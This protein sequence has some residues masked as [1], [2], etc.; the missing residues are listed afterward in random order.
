M[1]FDLGAALA[2]T[3]GAGAGV[4][5]KVGDGIK[6]KR[7]ETLEE[8]KQLAISR[9]QENL[10]RLQQQFQSQQGDLNRTH[11]SNQTDK[12]IEFNKNEGILNRAAA[13]NL[14]THDQGLADSAPTDLEKK[15]SFL[16][17]ILGEEK[18]NAYIEASVSSKTKTNLDR[19]KFY[20]EIY[21]G[22]IKALS[23]EMG[24]VTDEMKQ[25]ARTLAEQLSGY[26]LPGVSTNSE[27]SSLL[28][29]IK[30]A[31][32]S[33]GKESKTPSQE[34][35]TPTDDEAGILDKVASKITNIP[36]EDSLAGKVERTVK[37]IPQFL[38]DSKAAN[39]QN[40]EAVASKRTDGVSIPGINTFKRETPEA[41]TEVQRIVQITKGIL[42]SDGKSVTFQPED[43]KSLEKT[44]AELDKAGIA[45]NAKQGADGQIIVTIIE[46]SKVN[47]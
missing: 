10:Q 34:L 2:V 42:A 44:L 14:A 18:A 39:Q 17:S 43:Q 25:E 29:E 5:K 11:Q 33:K 23:G 12:T 6:E 19:E 31:G 4:A 40:L 32:I 3:G 13:K 46:D 26:R 7:R 47:I 21:T 37:N 36:Y 45:F 9:R 8:K 41:Q 15:H 20:Q 38:S 28:S 16:V 1:S 35:D 22:T 24:E 27:L 30:A